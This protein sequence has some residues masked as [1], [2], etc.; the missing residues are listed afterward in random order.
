MTDAEV[1]SPD[2]APVPAFLVVGLGASAGGVEALSSFFTHV[3]ADVGS[4]YVVILHLSPD[5]DSQLAAILQTTTPLPVAQVTERTLVMPNHVYVVPPDQHLTMEAG[6][7]AVSPNTQIEDRRAPVDIFFRTLAESHGERAVAVVLSGTGANG[8]MGLKRVKERGGA[9]FVQNPLEAGF[10]EMPRH[11]I[12]TGL[13]DDVLPVAAIPARIASY[14]T[15]NSSLAIPLEAD[16]RPADQQQALREIFTQLR[17]RTGHDFANYKRPTLLRRIARRITVRNMPNLPAYAAYLSDHPD[18]TIALLKELL[19]SVTNF[20]R[21]RSAFAALEHNVLPR[22]LVGK[23]AADQLR[24]WVVGCATGEEAYSIA[25][26]LAERTLGQLDAPKVQIFAT[27]IDEAAVARAREGRYTL[28]DAADVS[29]ERLRRFFSVEGDSYRV[30]R[31]IREMVL[32]ATHNVLKDPPFGHLDLVTCR[33]ML[34]YLN[35]QAQER[36]LET[37]HF[38]LNPGG[39]LFLGTSE[40]VEGAGDLFATLS[41]D[42]HIFQSRQTG[43][44][45]YPV[46]EAVP[47]F[48]LEPP[49]VTTTQQHEGRTLERISFGDL[50]QRL[51]E[52]YAPPSVVVNEEYDIVHLSERAGRYLQVAGGEPSTNLLALIRPELRLELRGAL[53]Q[54]AQRQTNVEARDLPIRIDERGEVVTIR[55]RPVLREGDP[56]RGFLLVLFEPSTGQPRDEEAAFRSDEP[57]TRQLEEE[58]LRVKAQL[59][60][61]SEQYEFQAEELKASNEELQAMNEEL[62]SA[63]EE[64]ETSKEELQSINEELRTVNQELKVKVEE[65]TLASNNLQNLVNSTNIGTIFL[66]RSF[67]VALFTPAT[68]ALFNL[69]P[70]DYGRP[71][72]DITHRLVGEDVVLDAEQVLAT[73]QPIEREVQ[74]SD[75]RTF[76]M[77]VLPY[78]TAEDQ[79]GGIVVTFLDVTE[80]RRAADALRASEEKYRTLFDSIDEGFCIIEVLFD[81]VGS[82]FDYRFLEM[83]PAFVAQTGL[84]EA[85]GRTVLELVPQH[86]R[87]WFEVYG[88]IARTGEA[89]RFQH[90]AQALKPPRWYDVYAFR[91][92]EPDEGRVAVIFNDISERKQSERE[93]TRTNR[94]LQ[95]IF[96]NSLQIIQLFNA[97]R[98][99]HSGAIVDF[100]WLMTNERWNELYGAMA[101]KRLLTENPAV[102]ETGLFDEFKQ[103]TETGVTLTQEHYYAYEQFDGWFLQTVA[104]VEDGFLLSTLDITE[105]KLREANLAFLAEVSQDLAGLTTIADTMERLGAKIGRFFDVTQCNFGELDAGED[106][107]T[108]LVFYG[109]NADHV[110]SLAGTYRLSDLL[111]EPQVKAHLAGELISVNDTQ[112]DA[113]VNAEAYASLDI[114]SFIIVPLV[115]QGVWQFMLTIADTK[116]RVWRDDDIELI[117][118]ITNRIWTRLERARIEQALRESEA[119]LRALIENLPGGA[120]FVVDRNLRYILAEGEALRDAGMEPG[121]LVGKTLAEALDPELAGD[122]TTHYGQALAGE[123]F[124]YE[125]ASHGRTYLTRGVPLRDAAG[126]V[127]AVLALSYEISARKRAEEA[128]LQANEQLETRVQARTAELTQ[129]M[130]VRQELLRQLVSAQEEERRRLARELHDQLGQPLSALRMGLAALPPA[131][132]VAR[133]QRLAAE[134]DADVDRLALELRPGALDDVGLQAA[135]EQHFARWGQQHEVSVEFA[136]VGLAGGRLPEEVEVVLYRVAQEALTNILKHAQ[137]RRVSM[138]LELRPH[139]VVL[140]VEDDGRGFDPEAVQRRSPADG[141]LGLLGMQERVAIVGGTLTIESTPGQGTTLFVRVPLP[142]R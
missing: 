135:L 136:T 58:L 115:R 30:R 7:I 131:D 123:P 26:L 80:R 61:S 62:R 78:R 128:L 45:T 125:H 44:R 121:D 70:A 142:V 32:F 107:D 48:R 140:I 77:R 28:N 21:D 66:D 92:G 75:G 13:V 117:R 76:L 106:T 6:Y 37:L 53:L 138:V 105:R 8:S 100:E 73:L 57:L 111:S 103:V 114:R 46:P 12:A 109:W 51:L 71:L 83:N 67:R 64:L 113:R 116:T 137:A 2:P 93:L 27:D 72:S 104:K 69:L 1:H 24:I 14:A 33:N 5:H 60:A 22:L 112:A 89:R 20:F 35:Q 119:L 133:L 141:R 120:A 63:A 54:A 139:L 29:P 94:L 31:E 118:E 110:R 68:R 42:D 17:L 127:Y 39:Y 49:R 98:D 82:P 23:T 108:L 18:E 88:E 97:V 65:T 15:R 130:A 16:P 79:I 91:V 40:S 126:E 52:Q 55:V 99:A 47:S 19:I 4:A 86:E 134:L 10:N 38:A 43:L 74:T 9:V 34:I 41:R 81:A 84:V 25:M 11:A 102:V 122:Y 85:T 101:G 129:L 96:D 36:V 50:H 56:A 59:R 87:F 132:A 3:Q 95:A 90:Q 124:V